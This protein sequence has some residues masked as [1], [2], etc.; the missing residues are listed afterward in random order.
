MAWNTAVATK[1][2]AACQ[3]RKAEAIAA[4]RPPVAPLGRLMEG[5]MIVA[6]GDFRLGLDKGATAADLTMVP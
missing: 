1:A 3:M 4:R 2:S 5:P 6:F